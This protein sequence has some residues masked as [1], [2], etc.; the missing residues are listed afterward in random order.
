MTTCAQRG[1]GTTGIH[2]LCPV[3]WVF[4]IDGLKV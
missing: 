2:T 1:N 4:T 3:D